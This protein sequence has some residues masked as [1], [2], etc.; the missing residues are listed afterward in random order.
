L[1][2]CHNFK[3]FGSCQ[4]IRNYLVTCFP[5]KRFMGSSSLQA[6][7]ERKAKLENVLVHLLRCCLLPGSAMKCC[8]ARR[9]LPVAL[10]QFLGVDEDIDKRSLLHILVDKMQQS[11]K[12]R[13]SYQLLQRSSSNCTSS[14]ISSMPLS[15]DDVEDVHDDCQCA[16]CFD[17]IDIYEDYEKHPEERRALLLPCKHIFHRTCIYEW[18][19]FQFGCPLCRQRVCPPANTKYVCAKNRIQWW[20]G[21]FTQDPVEED[22]SN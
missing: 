13:D 11:T 12:L 20:L 9:Q 14:T 4:A 6:L 15:M 19:M 1:Y 17:T 16:I 2:T 21:E 18:L 10:F 3:C 5:K 8:Q 22:D 7:D